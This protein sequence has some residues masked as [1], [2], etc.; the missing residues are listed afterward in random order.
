MLLKKVNFLISELEWLIAEQ[1]Q[2][3]Y[4]P[5]CLGGEQHVRVVLGQ[6]NGLGVPPKEGNA[7]PF[8]ST[9]FLEN[10]VNNHPRLEQT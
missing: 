10:P 5:R 8:L 1:S 3:F 2:E 6:L 4:S 7:K 9:L